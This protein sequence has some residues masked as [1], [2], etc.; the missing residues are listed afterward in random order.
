MVTTTSVSSCPADRLTAASITVDVPAPV[1]PLASQFE[2][3]PQRYHTDPGDVETDSETVASRPRRRT[4]QKTVTSV[5][6]PRRVTLSRRPCGVAA[7]VPLT[8]RRLR[9]LRRQQTPPPGRCCS[10]VTQFE[11]N[12][13][14]PLVSHRVGARCPADEATTAII[15]VA[16][17]PTNIRSSRRRRLLQGQI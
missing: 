11:S 8:K 15:T 4:R 14:C 10:L 13:C 16:R 2:S 1:L 17:V 5:A 3:K 7:A 6:A 9:S 12:P